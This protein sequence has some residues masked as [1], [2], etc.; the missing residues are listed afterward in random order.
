MVAVRIALC[1]NCRSSIGEHEVEL[2]VLRIPCQVASRH[3]QFFS[4][5]LDLSVLPSQHSS[6][7]VKLVLD[8]QRGA[9][10]ESDLLVV[11]VV[12]QEAVA[13]TKDV[14]CLGN[15]EQLCELVATG[16]KCILTFNQGFAPFEFHAWGD[17]K[18]TWLNW[19]F[20]RLYLAQL[21]MNQIMIPE[22]F[23]FTLLSGGAVVA[24]SVGNIALI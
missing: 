8:V 14:S 2:P 24:I 20:R 1:S 13:Y 4:R 22:L 6:A 7:I 9:A 23:D 16:Q 15:G 19:R 12:F 5:I 17:F 11:R 3:V 18:I 10:N 21:I